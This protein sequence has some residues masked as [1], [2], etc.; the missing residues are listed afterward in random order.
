ML[1]SYSERLKE[2]LDMTDRVRFA[3][4][5]FDRFRNGA[6]LKLLLN[7]KSRF[8]ALHLTLQRSLLKF[9]SNSVP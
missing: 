2:I 1:I 3:N 6:T 8:A 4:G 7:M 9:A 5:N